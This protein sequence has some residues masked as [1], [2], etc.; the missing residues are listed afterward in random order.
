MRTSTQAKASTVLDRETD[1]RFWAQTHYRVGERLNPK[2]PTDRAM[3]KVWMDIYGKVKREDQAGQLVLTHNHPAVEQH[4]GDAQLAM[5]AAAAHLDAAANEPDPVRAQQHAEAATVATATASAANQAAASFQPPTVSPV[6]V[7]AAAHEAAHAAAVPPPEPVVE[8]LP[9][10]HPAVLSIAAQPILPPEIATAPP[11]PSPP[12][13]QPRPGQQ[14]ALAQ[15]VSAP[16]VAVAVHEDAQA[17]TDQGAPPAAGTLPAQTIAVIRDIAVAVAQQTAG[18]IVGVMN[19]PDQ[20]WSWLVFPARTGADDWYGEVSEAPETFLYVAYFDKTDGDVWPE[21]INEM[22]G[23]GK[24]LTVTARAEP[25]A[26][27]RTNTAVVA[28]IAGL[29]LAGVAALASAR[30][31]AKPPL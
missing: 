30:K 6:V 1:A 11:A 29:A 12:T 24:A 26:R 14:L 7:S 27:P 16:A 5:Q 15:A 4:L 10:E 9:P 2:D 31:E 25:S 13:S 22:F 17:R 23:T 8:R 19:T 18:G 3:M 28:V 21:P 20:R